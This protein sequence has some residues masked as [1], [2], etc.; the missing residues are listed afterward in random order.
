MTHLY[1]DT[2][3]LVKLYVYES[4]TPQMLELASKADNQLTL[5]T[6]TQ[7]EF[8]SAVRS[9]QRAG[10]LDD[11]V[12][13]SMLDR[14]DNDLD[15]RFNR[16]AV[17]GYVIGP[18][19]RSCWAVSAAGVRCPSACGVS[20]I[21]DGGPGRTCLC[22]RGQGASRRRRVGGPDNHRPVIPGRTRVDQRFRTRLVVVTGVTPRRG[23]VG[24]RRQRHA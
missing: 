16:Q 19:S 22:L 3:A 17:N 18:R 12:S 11:S 9:R 5:S 1:L 13:E 14:F 23:G 21:Q 7:I 8:H 20:D 15:N 2:S 6:L 24:L 4:G 10:D